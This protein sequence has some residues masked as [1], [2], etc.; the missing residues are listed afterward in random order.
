MTHSLA[1]TERIL[2]FMGEIVGLTKGEARLEKRDTVSVPLPEFISKHTFDRILFERSDGLFFIVKQ[3]KVLIR[4]EIVVPHFQHQVVRNADILHLE[5][6]IILFILVPRRIFDRLILI[7]Q[8][9]GFA[10]KAYT[11]DPEDKEQVKLQRAFQAADSLY[12]S[13]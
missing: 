6:K 9:R 1:E 7:V 12:L 10:G 5:G 3:P 2:P 8:R 13:V 4:I 11:R